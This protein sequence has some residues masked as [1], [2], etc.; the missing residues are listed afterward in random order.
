MNADLNKQTTT[1]CY[2]FAKL[3]QRN[4]SSVCLQRRISNLSISWYARAQTTL[5]KHH[6]YLILHE[7]LINLWK[8]LRWHE[9]V[10]SWLTTPYTFEN[11]VTENDIFSFRAPCRT[12]CEI[13]CVSEAGSF[14]HS[15]VETEHRSVQTI[16]AL[17]WFP[18]FFSNEI[19]FDSKIC[20][21]WVDRS[22]AS[23]HAS[24]FIYKKPRSL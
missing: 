23:F 13:G 18:S 22:N 6:G 9:A 24:Q 14:E 16:D 15:S 7:Q 5:L 2:H 12:N 11:N 10:C 3:A 4:E 21:S 8:H 19:K 20:C 17:P 1:K